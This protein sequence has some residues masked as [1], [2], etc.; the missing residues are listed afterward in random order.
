MITLTLA[1]CDP[2]FHDDFIIV[3]N[4]NE[5]INVSVICTEGNEQ[6]F[7]VPAQSEYAFYT[8]EWVGGVSELKKINYIFKEITVTKDSMISKINYVDYTLWQQ[9]PVESSRRIFYYTDVKYF[10]PVNPEDFE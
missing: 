6:N 2:L 4:C 8:D 3:N 7:M 9:E 5:D 1:S 10:L